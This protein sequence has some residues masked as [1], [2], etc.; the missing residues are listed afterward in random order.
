MDIAFGVIGTTGVAL[1]STRRVHELISG[2]KEAP[3]AIKSLSKD[4]DALGN[5]LESLQSMLRN[6]DP[7]QRNAQ[8]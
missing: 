8:S 5:A 1:H 7:H 6:V 2:I 3:G 4:V